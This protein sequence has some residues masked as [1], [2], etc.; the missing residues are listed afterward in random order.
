MLGRFHRNYSRL[1]QRKMPK[2]FRIY[3]PFCENL[4]VFKYGIR[5]V[6]PQGRS[7]VR[8]MYIHMCRLDTARPLTDG[9]LVERKNPGPDKRIRKKV[10]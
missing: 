9:E 2:V 10:N 6:G 7:L 1:R 3:V 5:G 8:R 4:S